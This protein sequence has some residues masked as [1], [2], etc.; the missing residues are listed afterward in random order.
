MDENFGEV[1]LIPVYFGYDPRESIGAYVFMNSVLTRA[2]EPVSFIPLHLDAVRKFYKESHTD[3]TNNFIY[4]RFL[5][6]YMQGYQGWAIFVDGSDMLCRADIA[7]LWALRNQFGSAVQVVKHDYKTT[8]KRKYIGTDMEADN[9]DYPRKN[10]SSVMLI[11]CGHY[12]WRL[13]TP[14]FIESA[15]GSFLHRFEFLKDGEIGDLPKEWNHI[16]LEQEPNPEAKMVHYSL[17]IPGFDYYQNCEFSD[18]WFEEKEI[19]E[20]SANVPGYLQQPKSK[21]S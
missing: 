8:S 3:G 1:K 5:I 2:S 18:D 21:C 11:N 20:W 10:W 13:I 7:E 15:K 6:P 14:T 4:S 16:V 12:A 9:Q 17:G 19:M